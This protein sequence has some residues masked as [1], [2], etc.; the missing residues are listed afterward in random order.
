MRFFFPTAV[1]LFSLLPSGTRAF[2][3]VGVFPR[4]GLP[5]APLRETEW[6]QAK[7]T[8]SLCRLR[9]IPAL[10]PISCLL[11]LP[12]CSARRHRLTSGSY[13]RSWKAKKAL[14]SRL[15]S[16]IDH[17]ARQECSW[18]GR[19]L[20]GSVAKKTNGEPRFA[21]GAESTPQ[22]RLRA[23]TGRLLPRLGDPRPAEEDPRRPPAALAPK[24]EQEVASRA[25]RGAPRR[26]RR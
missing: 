21:S 1:A 20:R 6:A 26:R 9:M 22:R 18:L 16:G 4:R 25:A 14:R 23:A 11:A 10:L 24:G 7:D 13:P 17:P 8:T 12:A 2:L 3:P 5:P 19:S 15:A